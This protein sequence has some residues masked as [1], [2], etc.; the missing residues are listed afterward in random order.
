MVT[1]GKDLRGLA[2]NNKKEKREASRLAN[3]SKHQ[4]WKYDRKK[5]REHLRMGDIDSKG[6]SIPKYITVH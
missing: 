6:H 1:L 4:D 2:L 3:Q 5:F